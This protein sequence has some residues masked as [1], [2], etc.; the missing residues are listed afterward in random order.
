MKNL[1]PITREELYQKY[2]IKNNFSMLL[3][4]MPGT[5]K[6]HWLKSLA[7]T[8]NKT[9]TRMWTQSDLIGKWCPQ[10]KWDSI[11]F[12]NRID[13]EWTYGSGFFIID[14]FASSYSDLNNYGNSIQPLDFILE[15]LYVVWQRRQEAGLRNNVIITTNHTQAHLKEILGERSYS[16][17]VDMCTPYVVNSTVDLRQLPLKK[18]SLQSDI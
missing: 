18:R 5:G 11:D 9:H 1:T 2:T 15:A 14:D 3:M 10:S 8:V 7:K 6:T 16:R 17:L 4:G 12:E 13:L